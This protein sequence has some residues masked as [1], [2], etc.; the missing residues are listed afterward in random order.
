MKIGIFGDSFTNSPGC[1]SMAYHW[2]ELLANKL[3]GELDNYGEP[4][5]SVYFSYKRFLENHSKHDLCIFLVSEPNRYIKPIDFGIVNNVHVSGINTLNALRQFD[6]RLYTN[7]EG[8]FICSDNQYNQ[9]M[10][11]LMINHITELRK[12]VILLPS[13]ANSF[14]DSLKEKTGLDRFCFSDLI[15]YQTECLGLKI[16]H[17]GNTYF[18]K[19]SKEL[20]AGHLIPEINYIVFEKILQRININIWDWNLPDP[21]DIKLKHRTEEYFNQGDT[22]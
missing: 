18:A 3:D 16:E 13:F 12:D 15:K 8:W 11:E 19:E 5:S 14:S 2:S 6:E 21:K 10:T 17:Y 20:I 7:L 9:D 22:E 4:G 1:P